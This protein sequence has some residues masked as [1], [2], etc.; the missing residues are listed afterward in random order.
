MKTEKEIVLET[1][2]YYSDP[3]NRSLYYSHGEPK[4]ATSVYLSSNGNKCAVGR[5]MK[6]KVLDSIAKNRSI[7]SIVRGMCANKDQAHIDSLFKDEY[8]G[9]SVSFWDRLQR[10]HDEYSHWSKD[11][12]TRRGIDYV[13]SNFGIS[14]SAY[15]LN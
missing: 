9:H 14:L 3:D 6:D 12:I 8:R 5:C 10:L 15:I 1:V 4:D 13:E 2:E 7:K 11:G